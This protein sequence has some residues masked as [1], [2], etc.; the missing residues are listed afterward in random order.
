METYEFGILVSNQLLVWL[1]ETD[2]NLSKH[3]YTSFVMMGSS[4]RV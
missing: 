3:I 2:E 4:V 1:L